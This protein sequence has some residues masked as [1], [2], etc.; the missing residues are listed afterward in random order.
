MVGNGTRC[1]AMLMAFTCSL[2]GAG[3]TIVHLKGQGLPE[4]WTAKAPPSV[5]IQADS[6]R[7]EFR[8]PA[9]DRALLVSAPV[10]L[11]Q[12]TA[13]PMRFGA[14]IEIGSKTLA[15]SWF[16]VLL[17]D[18]VHTD[19]TK[20]A[21]AN[22]GLGG[23]VAGKPVVG[24]KVWLPA[25]AVKSLR[26]TIA[27][28]AKGS[29]NFSNL[30]LECPPPGTSAEAELRRRL[31]I[32]Y[33]EPT[34]QPRSIAG[35]GQHEDNFAACDGLPAVYPNAEIVWQAGALDN[36][37]NEF[38]AKINGMGDE[39]T[40]NV[41][42]DDWRRQ[43]PGG[44]DGR[45]GGKPRKLT[46]EF[47]VKESGDYSFLL[48]LSMCKN[49]WNK[50]RVSLD[51]KTLDE[52]TVEGNNAGNRLFS[53]F[54]FVAPITLDAGPHRIA[55]EYL[56]PCVWVTF[57]ALAL[58]QGKQRARYLATEF[59][60]SE[61]KPEALDWPELA[62]SRQDGLPAAG[63][64]SIAGQDFDVVIPAPDG[65]YQL[66]LEFSESF[67]KFDP[68]LVNKPGQRRFDVFV[69]GA[70][71]LAD[72]DIMAR[73]GGSRVARET[74]PAR[75]EGGRIVIGIKG[76]EK[77]GRIDAAKLLSL[78]GKVLASHEFAWVKAKNCRR[79]ELL[80]HFDAP[81]NRVANPGFER[82]DADG[83]LALW[84]TGAGGAG[85]EQA[86]DK[87]SQGKFCLKLLPGK[88]RLR[89]EVSSYV[90]YDHPYELTFQARA[91]GKGARVRPR[92][93][94][95]RN[96]VQYTT[97][98]KREYNFVKATHQVEPAGTA[99]G[100]WRELEP[101]W[102]K[103]SDTF[104][105]PRGADIAAFGLEWEGKEPIQV[106]GMLFDGQGALP[107]EIFVSQAGYEL[108]GRKTAV[109]FSRGD[110]GG[111]GRYILRDVRNGIVKHGDLKP[112]GRYPL[113]LADGTVLK[114]SLFN[115]N[116]WTADFSDVAQS[117]RHVLEVIL[118]DGQS[119]RTPPFDIGAGK[120]ETLGRFVAENY[121]PVIRCGADVPGW[122][123]PCHMDDADILNPDG[124]RTHKAIH[125]GWHDAGDNNLFVFNIVNCSLAF[126]QFIDDT[127][128][129]PALA[130]ELA[131]GL[132]FLVR[133]QRAD[134][135]IVDRITGNPMCPVI[136]PDKAPDGAPATADNRI[137][138]G[139]LDLEHSLTA[140]T[141]LFKGAK[142]KL[143]NAALY[144]TAADKLLARCA[145]GGLLS[146][147]RATPYLALI[148]LES[149]KDATPEL[150]K[151]LQALEDGSNLAR[152]PYSADEG[153]C[154]F[155]CFA[156]AYALLEQLRA[157]PGSPLAARAKAALRRYCDEALIPFCSGSPFDNFQE[158]RKSQRYRLVSPLRS[159]EQ[160]YRCYAAFVMAAAA[161]ALDD[162]ALL[163]LA[164]AQVLWCVGFNPCGVSSIAGVGWR[165]QNAFNLGSNDFPGHENGQYPGA[166]QHGLINS[167]GKLAEQNNPLLPK[168]RGMPQGSFYA[169]PL[170]D[171]PSFG[172]GA[173]QYIAHAAPFIM[174]CGKIVAAR[175]KLSACSKPQRTR[176]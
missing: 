152:W 11:N 78:D 65:Q 68:F 172:P 45:Q 102:T 165:Q 163:R 154:D 108:H 82:V 83:Q 64:D 21:G 30:F 37:G 31:F 1:L 34:Y 135:G 127:K 28:A 114:E 25:K 176:Y 94:F 123:P 13:T 130:A 103:V 48:A 133:A 128:A 164:E 36:S 121:F 110:G 106:D 88:G 58:L 171:T 98:Q 115:R 141:A 95:F 7:V 134:G 2:A 156:P 10:V 55:I 99:Y 53:P 50:L 167:S 20:G 162:P 85:A 59:T 43:F 14:E 118:A 81:Y 92:L 146:T 60:P 105:P 140:V 143:P 142:L 111:H 122:H 26:V 71:V 73:S 29:S 139:E 166:T 32:P 69:N 19:G 18:V 9:G 74:V 126:G 44:V 109:V 56:A 96:E 131:W 159:Y 170:N 89:S 47:N 86:A 24:D 27:G 138:S 33:P 6:G 75:S 42:K 54:R 16:D 4:Q 169:L 149:G 35:I 144:R 72:Y 63:R 175:Q 168:Y 23:F 12:T 153:E 91:D 15:G 40:F 66:E 113:A 119:E 136:R 52:Y 90:A 62:D 49:L 97:G 87:P 155:H 84:S 125:G 117:G 174:A 120:F 101:G 145:A 39:W 22:L 57:D 51:G 61:L 104:T 112:L 93:D 157:S 148:A 80:G 124:S 173:E 150:L 100:E 70:K 132:D 8:N 151:L 76:K 129:N 79:Q 158:Y 5:T 147:D 137:I 77:T 41:T 116:V 46:V 67:F 107:L 38:P 3:E 161:Q 160:S 17:T